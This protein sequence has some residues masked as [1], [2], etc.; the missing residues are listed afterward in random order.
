MH[1]VF[2][3]DAK[4]F[5]FSQCEECLKVWRISFSLANQYGHTNMILHLGKLANEYMGT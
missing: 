5:I 2:N 1:E 4:E 3:L